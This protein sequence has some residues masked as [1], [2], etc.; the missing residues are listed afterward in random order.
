MPEVTKVTSKGQV[1]I[2]RDIR[3]KL[4]LASGSNLLVLTD[5]SNLLLKPIDTL[6]LKTFAQLVKDSRKL[7]ARKR[8]RKGEVAKLIQRVRHESRS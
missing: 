7:V 3:E 8:I 1:V 6:S 2:P 5:G 4:G